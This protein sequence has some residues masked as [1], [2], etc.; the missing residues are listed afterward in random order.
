MKK[1]KN[2]T[3]KQKKTHS[4]VVTKEKIHPEYRTITVRCVCGNETNTRSTSKGDL[5]VEICS[6]CHPFYTG[7]QKLLDSAGRVE[8]FLRKYGNNRTTS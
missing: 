3:V 1:R 5:N 7:K 2:A 6:E 4:Y 8:R